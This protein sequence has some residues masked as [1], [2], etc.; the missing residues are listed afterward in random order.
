[1]QVRENELE[2]TRLAPQPDLGITSAWMADVS[3]RFR[4]GEHTFLRF[5]VESYAMEGTTVLPRAVLFNGTTLAS[6]RAL[7]TRMRFP[8][9]VRLLAVLEHD[10][11][12]W[13]DTRVMLGAG[14]T[15]VA[16]TVR[17]QGTYAAT[18]VR[19]EA[20]EDFVTQELPIPLVEVGF[21]RPLVRLLSADATAA[22]GYLPRVNSLRHEGGTVWLSQSHIDLDLRLVYAL[23]P[24]WHVDVGYRYSSFAQKEESAE[25]GNQ[26]EMSLS[27][28]RL[29]IARSFGGSAGRERRE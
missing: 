18:T 25:D 24:A 10:T 14:L 22:A 13:G 11:W 26:V 16:L 6:G 5:A 21:A 7:T 2:G 19:R 20:K 8:S 1:M 3:T 17:M 28:V 9:F 27:G 29:G 23:R 15:F 12:R 4:P